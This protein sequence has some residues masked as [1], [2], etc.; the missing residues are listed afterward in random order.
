MGWKGISQIHMRTFLHPNFNMGNKVMFVFL[1]TFFLSS[2]EGNKNGCYDSG[3][4]SGTRL[5]LW[6]KLQS[7]QWKSWIVFG[8][9]E[10]VKFKQP[11]AW[12]QLSGNASGSAE[13]LFF[14]KLFK[15]GLVFPHT[16]LRNACW[17]TRLLICFL[18]LKGL[19]L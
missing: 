15:W 13:L 6:G 18:S 11:A 19:D 2:R 12:R 8:M 10:P 16:W 17:R 4:A 5:G 14:V 3:T 1:L 9:C 7:Q